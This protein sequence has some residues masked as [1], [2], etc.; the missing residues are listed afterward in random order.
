MLILY[1]IES[2][3]NKSACLYQVVE[4]RGKVHGLKKQFNLVNLAL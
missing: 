1:K 4:I 3:I 2:H